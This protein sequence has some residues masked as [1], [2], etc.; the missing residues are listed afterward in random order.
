MGNAD[1]GYRPDGLDDRAAV[2]NRL[3]KAGRQQAPLE[4]DDRSFRQAEAQR[5]ATE[6]V[7]DGCRH[8]ERSDLSAVAQRAKAEA[9]HLAAKEWIASSLTLLAMT[10]GRG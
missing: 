8:C 4:T 3:R 2:R 1:E 10:D 6:F 5:T 7:L 9:I